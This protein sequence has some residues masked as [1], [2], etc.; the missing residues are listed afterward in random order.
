[1]VLMIFLKSSF[2]MLSVDTVEMLCVLQGEHSDALASMRLPDLAD[3]LEELDQILLQFSSDSYW[4]CT[5]YITPANYEFF[6]RFYL[7][8]ILLWFEF[9]S[10]LLTGDKNCTILF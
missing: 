3:S 2:I 7:Q 6:A 8:E 9:F 5:V 1:M 4:Q 10:V